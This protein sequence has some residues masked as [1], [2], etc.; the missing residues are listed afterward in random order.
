MQAP[1]GRHRF[2]SC[3][4]HGAMQWVGGVP[5]SASGSPF[6]AFELAASSDLGTVNASQDGVD[7]GASGGV[8]TR[9][10]TGGLSAA[11]PGGR[12]A[13]LAGPAASEPASPEALVTS[14]LQPIRKRRA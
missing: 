6:P 9:T 5:P 7:A 1:F 2:I 14:L 3:Q 10:S 4:T 8:L 11:S 13:S 12:A